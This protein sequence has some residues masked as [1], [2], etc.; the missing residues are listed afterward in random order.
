MEKKAKAQNENNIIIK[1]PE[2][3][4]VVIS[5]TLDTFKSRVFG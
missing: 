5:P 1:N 4:D 3:K 2:F